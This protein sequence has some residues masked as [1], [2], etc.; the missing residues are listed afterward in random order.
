MFILHYHVDMSSSEQTISLDG[1]HMGLL[2]YFTCIY[3]TCQ[4]YT[5]RDTDTLET[6]DMIS[7]FSNQ[8]N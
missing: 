5:F 6:F 2:V 7:T 4:N 3:V 8:V 1:W